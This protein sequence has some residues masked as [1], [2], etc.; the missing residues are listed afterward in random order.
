MT[1]NIH[2]DIVNV[3]TITVYALTTL[4]A[5]AATALG[6]GFLFAFLIPSYGIFVK[7]NTLYDLCIMQESEPDFEMCKL[8]DKWNSSFTFFFVICTINHAGMITICIL[9]PVVVQLPILFFCTFKCKFDEK[10][11]FQHRY[12]YWEHMT[13][14]YKT[15]HIGKLLPFSVEKTKL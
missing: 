9:V 14:F 1:V 15:V 3:A 8:V 5:F 13:N 2:C 11:F 4:I 12:K 6:R 7:K 10:F